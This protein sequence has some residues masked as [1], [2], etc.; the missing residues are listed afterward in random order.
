MITIKNRQRKIKIDIDRLHAQAQKIL[1]LLNYADF[2]LGILLTTNASIRIYNREFRHKDTPTDILSFALYPKIKAGEPIKV[3]SED[4]K[5][6]GDLVIS[7]EYV[8]RA[9]AK[10]E[11]AFEERMTELLVHGVCHLLGYDHIRDQD[12]RKMRKKELFLLKELGYTPKD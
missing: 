5:N 4:E 7:V 2:D 6:L 10:L 8:Q 11:M 1:D 12:Y 3:K 9:A